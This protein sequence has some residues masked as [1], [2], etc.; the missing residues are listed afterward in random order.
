MNSLPYAEGNLVAIAE[1]KS[2]VETNYGTEQLKS[3]LCATDPPFGILASGTNR[4]SWVFLSELAPQP[5]PVN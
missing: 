3:Y 4:D 2:L 5:F 1:C